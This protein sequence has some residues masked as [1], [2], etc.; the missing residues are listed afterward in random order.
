MKTFTLL[1]ISCTVFLSFICV[2]TLFAQKTEDP[3]AGNYTL[4]SRAQLYL[5]YRAANFP[6]SY[7]YD[8]DL[9]K[10]SISGSQI[11]EEE[12]YNSSYFDVCAGDFDGDGQDEAVQ[13][14]VVQTTFPNSNHLLLQVS[15]EWV[16]LDIG[17]A[18]VGTT[19]NPSNANVRLLA[20]N[21]C[22]DGQ[23]E[24][25][26]S[27]W[28]MDKNIHLTLYFLDSSKTIRELTTVIEPLNPDLG[29][30]AMFDIAA[31]D[32]DA[33]GLEEIVL[34][35]NNT[36][37]VDPT[38]ANIANLNLRIKIYAYDSDDS[39]L[40]VKNT[41]EIAR[42]HVYKWSSGV[43]NFYHTYVRQLMR[44][45]I[46]A[47]NLKGDSRDE[48][49][50]GYSIK[51]DYQQKL[52]NTKWWLQRDLLPYLLSFENSAPPDSPGQFQ[53][54]DALKNST[55]QY[56]EIS[57]VVP[58][59]VY[60]SEENNP[61]V[62]TDF[63]FT[64]LCADLDADGFDEL[65]SSGGDSINVI[66]VALHFNIGGPVWSI[67]D[68]EVIPINPVKWSWGIPRR[69]F[70]VMDVDVDTA[71]IKDGSDG[72]KTNW[73]PELIIFDC[74]KPWRDQYYGDIFDYTMRISVWGV[75]SQGDLSSLS[76]KEVRTT[77]ENINLFANH[78][79]ALGDFKG[80]GLRLG[81]P[82]FFE[83]KE[84]I[85]PAVVLNAPPVHYDILHVGTDTFDVC[86]AFND[87][88]SAFYSEYF[89]ENDTRAIIETSYHRDWG[90]SA[91]LT[92]KFFMAGSG[93]RATLVG[94]YGNGFSKVDKE[95]KTF[96]VSAYTRVDLDDAVYAFSTD[97]K[98]WEYP[99]YYKQ[100]FLGHV[101]VADP[102]SESVHA[103]FW[104][105]GRGWSD[106]SYVPN[107][108][109]GNILSYAAPGDKADSLQ[110]DTFAEAF[111]IHPS[112][113]HQ[114]SIR[115]ENITSDEITKNTE[116]GISYDL[117]T[118]I[119]YE[120]EVSAEASFEPIGIGLAAGVSYV[121]DYGFETGTSNLYEQDEIQTFTTTLSN[122]WQININ[123]G[124]TVPI[125]GIEYDV[126]PYV[127]W[128][129][130]GTLILDYVVDPRGTWW[131]SQYGSKPDLALILPKLYW[132]EKG[133]E[134]TPGYEYRR[135]E[136]KDIFLRPTNPTPGDTVEI[137]TR[138]HNYSLKEISP[139]DTVTVNYYLGDPDFGGEQITDFVIT[140]RTRNPQYDVT[141]PRG[142]TFFYARW[143]IPS[144]ISTDAR[145][146]VVIDAANTID[147]IHE[148]NNKGYVELKGEGTTSIK[149]LATTTQLQDY[150]LFQNYPNP[151]N[152]DTQIRFTVA[153][154]EMV[155]IDIFN[156][157]GQR[158]ENLI[159]KRLEPG[160]YEIQFRAKNIA[161]GL[162]FY[163]L[164]AGQFTKVQKMILLK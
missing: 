105:E 155:T 153:R 93:V 138:V 119:G 16:S 20:G 146:Y 158:V 26:V 36:S 143:I 92:G 35:K 59:F 17:E 48:F 131:E 84:L 55:P 130:N 25:V 139:V 32:F 89:T 115:V 162:Y 118:K 121:I 132:T 64:L 67:E 117:L 148:N 101:L 6:G 82:R 68:R 79:M 96:T 164:S 72:P 156:M 73:L 94:R 61:D 133:G 91:S 163:R 104:R 124:N 41:M 86:R 57:P 58:D 45:S 157:L 5:M 52:W 149:A 107:H 141:V 95:T 37:I 14:T 98:M 53:I 145:L 150:H 7:R 102:T 137:L 10:K 81:K 99:V 134:F 110:I 100:E 13:A 24:F 126:K 47:G 70:A 74:T 154:S 152:P 21:F 62:S 69:Q 38:H 39:A 60:L 30:E 83:M 8:F 123:L 114:K 122:T 56:W 111:P 63:P 71:S 40:T 87:N 129:H 90:I 23:K 142:E 44:L 76:D 42:N 97:Y 80:D 33:D 136:T 160:V 49:I 66:P 109:V 27:Y 113:T 127:Y 28:D 4:G 140:G 125:D 46:A 120:G 1:R 88:T 116:F 128:S 108:E 65:I 161:S 9:E 29:S 18:N 106:P 103:R 51:N 31:G 15:G 159:N 34:V 43:T 144:D 112:S 11:L 77:L 85:Q 78:A 50:I 12:P 19:D 2:F 75:T 22:G 151:F 147:E 54:D 3:F 135:Y